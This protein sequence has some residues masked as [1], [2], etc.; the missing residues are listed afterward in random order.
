MH[1]VAIKPLYEGQVR[2]Q[3]FAWFENEYGYWFGYTIHPARELAKRSGARTWRTS[4]RR[5]PKQTTRL[6]EPDDS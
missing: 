6:A 2:P 1:Q 3:D 5:T 4:T